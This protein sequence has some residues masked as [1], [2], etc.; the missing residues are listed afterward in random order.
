M[1]WKKSLSIVGTLI[2][3]VGQN[4]AGVTA[5]AETISNQ[6]ATTEDIYFAKE[7][8]KI[9]E[10]TLK[11]G[12]EETVS[13]VDE[14]KEDEEV[15]VIL[16][17]SAKLNQ[18]ATNSQLGDASVANYDQNTNQVK[19]MFK[20]K[21]QEVKRTNLVLTTND[22]AKNSASQIYAQT[23]RKDGKTYKSMSV[24]LSIIEN[25]SEESIQ[26]TQE[27]EDDG[28]SAQEITPFAGNLNVDLDISPVSNSVLSGT[29]ADYQLQFKVTGSQATYHNA[30]ISVDL[31]AGAELAQDLSELTVA[32]VVPIREGDQLIWLFDTLTAGQA[33]TVTLKLATKNGVT[34]NGTELE[35]TSNFMADEFDTEAKSTAKVT[36]TA[37]ST[38]AAA[39]KYTS[40]K[41]SSGKEKDTPPTAGDTGTWSLSVNA[42]NKD[43]G[44]LY[45]KEGSTIKIIDVIPE[46]LTY[47]S[48]NAGGK[49]DAATRTVTWEFPAPS[50]EEQ[51]NAGSKLF[52]KDIQVTTKFN[53]D[54]ENMQQFKNVVKASAEDISGKTVNTEASANVSAG[55]SDPNVPEIPSGN[56]WVLQH[57]GPLDGLSNVGYKPENANP[58]PSVYDW[59]D[60]GFYININPNSAN[61]PTKNMEKY[62]INYFID[63]NL[64]LDRIYIPSYIYSPDATEN[65]DGSKYWDEHKLEGAEHPDLNIYV[66][67]NGEEKQIVEKAED[68]TTYTLSDLG[69]PK[70]THVEKIRYDWTYAPA[71]M[72]AQGIRSYYSVEKGYT[73]RVTNRSVWTIQGYRSNGNPVTVNTNDLSE[74]PSNLSGERYA[75]VIKQPEGSKIVATSTIKFDTQKNGIVTPGENRITGTF[76]NNAT[77]NLPM[78]GPLEAMVLLPEGVKVNEKDTRYKFRSPVT[79]SWDA[80]N[81]NI[82]GNAKIITNNYNN[83]NRQLVKVTWSA[84]QMLPNQSAG[85]GFNVIIDS[86][87]PVP[88]RMDTRGYSG[89]DEL[90]V[91]SGA[92]SLTDS[93]LETDKDDMNGDGD[94][95]QKRVL[96]SNEYKMIRESSI[97]TEKLVKGEQ[98]KD[99]SKMGHTS[100]NG[101]IDYQLSMTNKG[102][103]VGT[104]T[105]LEVLPSVGDLGITDNKDRGSLF[106]P[107]LTGPVSLPDKWE[108]H[109][110]VK[111]STATNPSRKDLSNQV[112][113]PGTTE[114]LKDPAGAQNPNWM[115][116]S[117]VSDWSSIHSFIVQMEGTEWVTGENVTFNFSMKAPSN[118]SMDLLNQDVPDKDR[119]AWNSFAYTANNSQV[120]EPERV[121]VVVNGEKPTIEKDVEEKEHLDLT[122]RDD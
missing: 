105:M 61:N 63:P 28:E 104:F 91:P 78:N 122:N 84:A 119:S 118:V 85:Y 54:I 12:T 19:I 33:D 101:S 117:D 42:N 34:P 80:D 51:E 95:T 89:K 97:V 108:G 71:G 25:D 11:Q 112:I 10:I 32:G 107:T 94:S 13:V 67:I 99:Y 86:K 1:N 4:I 6:E 23:V 47:V 27:T 55:V 40:T 36:V 82:N 52:E 14:N 69:I 30:K 90:T 103:N 64:N 98:D 96:S 24:N 102:D 2:M 88:L 8:T 121:G 21:E 3:V 57:N 37:G 9:S 26:E 73:G 5:F 16:P 74:D 48:D 31:P 49:Y 115:D 38:L 56:V 17:E 75:E 15:T 35:V 76:N 66:T 113:Y 46:G 116:A 53:D 43:T 72:R 45:F 93:Y 111:Y 44:L 41:D 58:D 106:T 87:A 18:E 81:S 7:N 110:T 83:S 20:N 39:K 70:G 60:L 29:S 77:S 92:S 100:P 68:L 120:V 50:I 114:Q 79:G 62:E 22:I 65:A 59:A 109:A